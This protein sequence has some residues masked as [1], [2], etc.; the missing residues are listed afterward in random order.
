MRGGEGAMTSPPLTVRQ[1]KSDHAVW[2]LVSSRR[3]SLR[4]SVAMR[5]VCAIPHAHPHGSEQREQQAE[6]HRA[7]ERE[8]RHRR[9]V[10]VLNGEGEL[11]G[12]QRRV[13][14][15]SV[16]DDGLAVVVLGVVGDRDRHR[17]RRFAVGESDRGR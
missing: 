15:L 3:Q 4:K 16:N 11:L 12:G 17:A 1:R 10:V 5:N 13:R 2:S 7:A 6:Q 14:A 8:R 9:H